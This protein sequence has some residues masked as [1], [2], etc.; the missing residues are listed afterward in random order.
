MGINNVINSNCPT[1]TEY[2]K[3]LK[4]DKTGFW[5]Y[6][7]SSD[8]TWGSYNTITLISS[9]YL[10]HHTLI[11]YKEYSKRSYNRVKKALEKYKEECKYSHHIIG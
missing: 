5:Q 3:I 4:I 10:Y 6:L 2:L 7:N 8:V 11:L 9:D 1:L